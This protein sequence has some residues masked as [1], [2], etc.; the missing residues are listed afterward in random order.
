MAILELAS[1]AVSDVVQQ[2]RKRPRV[3]LS[4][5]MMP[6]AKVAAVSAE[7]NLGTTQRRLFRSSQ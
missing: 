4:W 7:H 3:S 2:V 5:R 6:E 1:K